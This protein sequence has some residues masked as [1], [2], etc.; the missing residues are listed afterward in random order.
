MENKGKQPKV[1]ESRVGK[2]LLERDY[3]YCGRC[4]VGFFP[5]G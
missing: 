1:V 4:E 3:Y 2:V 5:P